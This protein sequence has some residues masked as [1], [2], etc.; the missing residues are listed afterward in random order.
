MGL[1]TTD[2]PE[3]GSG[4]INKVLQPGNTVI[5]ITSLNLK[6]PPFDEKQIEI[7]FECEGEPIEGFEGFWVDKDDPSKGRYSGQVGRVRASEWNFKDG[8][9]GNTSISRDA[10]IMKYLLQFT[11]AIGK[12][13]WLKDQ[14]DKHDTIEEL[15]DQM[16]KDRPFKDIWL[17]ACLGGRSYLNKDGFVNYDLYFPKFTAKS[18]P[19]EIKGTEPSRLIKFDKDAHIKTPKVKKADKTD[20]IL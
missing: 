19:L 12:E 6:R 14:D 5:K 18:V 16:N 9:I 20:F 15:L 1:S 17:S 2:I 4:I 13:Q 10:E 11:R 8:N 3:G 7:G